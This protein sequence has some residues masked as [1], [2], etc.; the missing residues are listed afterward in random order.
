MRPSGD[1]GV[2][3]SVFW[4]HF[5]NYLA[6]L[7]LRYL[8]YEPSR[9]SQAGKPAS[10]AGAAVAEPCCHSGE[11]CNTFSQGSNPSESVGCRFVAKSK[12]CATPD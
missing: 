11:E 2:I 9:S 1:A 5:A 6:Y 8:A 7:F 3:R 4:C 12:V 10:Q